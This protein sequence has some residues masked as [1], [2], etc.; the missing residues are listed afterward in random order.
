MSG[1][2]DQLELWSTRIAAITAIL[3]ALYGVYRFVK[4]S[5]IK[6]FGMANKINMISEQLVSNGGSSLRD[7]ITR[8]EARQ[9][10]IE[11]RERAFLHTHPNMMC[12]LD[13]NLCLVWANKIFLDTIDVD[14]DSLAGYG[15]HN[16]VCERDR[17]RVL[18]QFEDAKDAC[19]NVM[20]TGCFV[21][22]GD[23]SRRYEANIVATVMRDAVMQVSGY[24]VTVTLNKKKSEN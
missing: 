12:E 13:N 3:G 10:H 15:W 21:V 19:R 9:I 5:V 18:Q 2:W 8:I 24:L 22:G 1:E 7:C 16:I 11:Q 20:T 4:S 23:A 6:I 14:S 17:D